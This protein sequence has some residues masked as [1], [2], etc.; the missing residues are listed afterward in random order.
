VEIAKKC[1]ELH[2][3]LTD[4]FYTLARQRAVSGIPINLPVWWVAPHDSIA[5]AID[6]GKS[7]SQAHRRQ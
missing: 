1:V 2:V 3:K 6:S 7:L 4:S 5:Q